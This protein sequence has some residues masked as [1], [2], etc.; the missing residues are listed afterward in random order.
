MRVEPFAATLILEPCDEVVRLGAARRLL[1]LR[2]GGVGTAEHDVVSDRTV[3][4]RRI[5]RDHADMGT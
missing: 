5:L 3:Q 1:Q 2:F 4:Q